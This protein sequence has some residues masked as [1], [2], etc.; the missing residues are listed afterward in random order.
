MG[1]GMSVTVPASEV[2]AA[3]SILKENGED[4]YVIGKIIKSDEKIIIK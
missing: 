3:L 4:A 2:D 1:V